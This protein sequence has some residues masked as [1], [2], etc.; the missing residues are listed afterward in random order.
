MNS[1][2]FSEAVLETIEGK[3]APNLFVSELR[4]GE[5]GAGKEETCSLVTSKLKTLIVKPTKCQK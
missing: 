2:W 4:L 1:H 3:Q 5:W